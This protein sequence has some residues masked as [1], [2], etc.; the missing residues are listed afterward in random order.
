MGGHSEGPGVVGIDRASVKCHGRVIF[1]VAAFLISNGW[2][3]IDGD[4]TGWKGIWRNADGKQIE[5]HAKS[6]VGD[7]VATLRDGR[8]LR[9]EAKKGPL[10]KKEGSK[11]YP[12][13]REAI[14]QLMTASRANPDDLP[15]VLVPSSEKFNQL[16][17]DWNQLP[18]MQAAGIKIVTIDRSNQLQHLWL[19]G[20]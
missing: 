19:N 10:I 13:I 8:R 20:H 14:G 9:A 18:L 15:I 7:V 17:T 11:E 12:L 2:R 6:G 3:R 4:E 5:V 16:A 1:P